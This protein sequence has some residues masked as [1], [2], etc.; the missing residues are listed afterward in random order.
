MGIISF[1]YGPDVSLSAY[2][3]HYFILPGDEFET[4]ELGLVFFDQAR[5]IPVEL[6]GVD[7]PFVQEL[8]SRSYL[9]EGTHSRLHHS[10][11]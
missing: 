1:F 6:I 2:R 7:S 10:T 9:S 8:P 3:N 5:H 4:L 11:A